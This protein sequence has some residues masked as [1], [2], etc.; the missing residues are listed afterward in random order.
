MEMTTTIAISEFKAHCIA[1]LK[2]VNEKGHDLT[3]THRGKPLVRIESFSHHPVKREFGGGRGTGKI[4][5]EIIETSDL[6]GEWGDGRNL[7]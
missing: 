1:L 7:K 4:V 6:L 5:G 2:A 3:V